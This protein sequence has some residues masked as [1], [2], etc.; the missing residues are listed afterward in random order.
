MRS[1]ADGLRLSH[2]SP[3]RPASAPG[4]GSA[5][6]PLVAA[7]RRPLNRSLGG[8]LRRTRWAASWL[9]LSAGLAGVSGCSRLLSA[10]WARWRL[11]TFSRSL[12]CAG[13]GARRPFGGSA[14]SRRG[15]EWAKAITKSDM[16]GALKCHVRCPVAGPPRHIRHQDNVLQ[17]TGPCPLAPVTYNHLIY[18]NSNH[19]RPAPL[20]PKYWVF[21]GP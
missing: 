18:S 14:A 11:G 4:F 10:Q 15:S 1:P 19:F 3:P 17:C 7:R 5:P 9:P 12:P 6:K 2:S 8:G 20:A 21:K 16:R 13:G